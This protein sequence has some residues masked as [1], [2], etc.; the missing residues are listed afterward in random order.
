[1]IQVGILGA[2]GRM[3]Q[4]ISQLIRSEF[5]NSAVISSEVSRT[6]PKAPLL[7]CDVVIDFSSPDGMKELAKNALSTSSPIPA[8]VVGSTGWTDEDLSLLHE[9]AFKSPVLKASNFSIGVFAVSEILQRYSKL[10][11]HLGYTPVLVET[12]HRHKKDSPS[13]TALS[14][15]NSIDPLSPEQ[16]QTHSI[17]AG[18]VIGDHKVS[19]FGQGDIITIG[20]FAKD[21][22]IFARGA[23]E[24]ALWLAKEKSPPHLCV[25]SWELSSIL[26]L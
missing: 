18:E 2:K 14:L 21:R 12:H 23:I 6:D 15:R 25:D 24:V 1:L 3:G 5:S 26:K 13:G 9:L 19:F 4:M 8:F 20:H 10:L 11:K 17:R 7:K 22:A 16:V